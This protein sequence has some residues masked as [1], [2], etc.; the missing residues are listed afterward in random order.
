MAQYIAGRMVQAIVVLLGVSAVVFF[1]LFLTG[2]PAVLMMSPD[3][4]HAELDAFRKSM[5][6]Y[7]PII[8]QYGRYLWRAIHGDLGS[9]LRFQQSTLSLVFERLPA[10]VL[11]ALSALCWSPVGGALAGVVW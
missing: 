10:T 6:F 9:S 2:D 1:A 7:D 3:A 4:S 8:V 5:G 11:L